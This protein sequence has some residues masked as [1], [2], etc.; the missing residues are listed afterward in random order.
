MSHTA[1]MPVSFTPANMPS[2]LD[3]AMRLNWAYLKDDFAEAERM[4]EYDPKDPLYPHIDFSA[5]QDEIVVHYP[6]WFSQW[7]HYLE[8][9]YGPRSN[10]PSMV[11]LR[12]LAYRE[13]ERHLD[14]AVRAFR[15][16]EGTAPR[17]KVMVGRHDVLV[18]KVD[19]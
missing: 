18:R 12:F 6:S 19:L 17:I 7:N 15:Q 2:L 11:H 10:M 9:R 4:L 16:M 13:I 5:K 8:K 3:A 14:P 1:C